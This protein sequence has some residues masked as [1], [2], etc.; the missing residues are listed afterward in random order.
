ME[1]KYGPTEYAGQELEQWM[2]SANA[3]GCQIAR[4]D[5]TWADISTIDWSA[6][7][8]QGALPSE[9]LPYI[10]ELN[11][12]ADTGPD[13][14][15]SSPYRCVMVRKTAMRL[16]ECL[17]W[18][19]HVGP[20]VIF[21]DVLSRT[22]DSPVYV[23][24]VTKAIYE[25]E[26]DLRALRYVFVTCVLNPNTADAFKAICQSNR[27]ENNGSKKLTWEASSSEFRVLLGTRIGK[28]VGRFVLGAYGQGVKRIARIAVY[29][30]PFVES[31]DMRFDIED[32]V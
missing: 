24:E 7:Y 23:N 10:S 13:N 22:V 29:P 14:V 3:P 2:E 27:L 19:G 5:L 21:L 31:F 17:R 4:I 18:I 11:L 25:R 8:S 32:V 20:G 6:T 15:T 30:D 1:Y 12:P 9:F 16:R 28:S 26:F